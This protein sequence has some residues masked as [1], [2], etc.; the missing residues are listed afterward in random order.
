MDDYGVP[1]GA[2]LLTIAYLLLVTVLWANI[3]L[4]LIHRG[5]LPQP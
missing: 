4:E 3:Y 5:G 2:L 1:K